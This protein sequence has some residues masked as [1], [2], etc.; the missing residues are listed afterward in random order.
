MKKIF[1][2]TCYFF[3]GIFVYSHDLAEAVFECDMPTVQKYVEKLNADLNKKTDYYI[4]NVKN[5]TYLFISVHNR[6]QGSEIEKRRMVKY[7]LEHGALID[8]DT[9]FYV[10]EFS[11]YEMLWVLY[12]YGN[13]DN[14][15]TISIGDIEAS[16]SP[17]NSVVNLLGSL[18][19]KESEYEELEKKKWTLLDY[20]LSSYFHRWHENYNYNVQRNLYDGVYDGGSIWDNK[21]TDN[22]YMIEALCRI[23]S[24]VNYEN[25]NHTVWLIAEDL[26]HTRKY[27]REG[28]AFRNIDFMAMNLLRNEELISFLKDLDF[29]KPANIESKK[30]GQT[31]FWI[32]QEY[33]KGKIDSNTIKFLKAVYSERVN[34]S[35]E[36]ITQ[37]ILDC[38]N[39]GINLHTQLDNFSK[40][41]PFIFAAMYCY[42]ETLEK[43]I[44]VDKN[45][46]L[47]MYDYVS[48]DVIK[49]RFNG[50]V[51]D[52]YSMPVDDIIFVKCPTEN[53]K[54]LREKF[55][56]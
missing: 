2:L 5:P 53:I 35:S 31:A 49:F 18:F 9:F 4:D 25:C 7:L 39:S 45:Y 23:S 47:K 27:L 33:F 12:N 54:F 17:I 24:T 13:F 48:D 3:I 55:G 32:L 38:I 26:D 41:N 40:Y 15:R 8:D 21:D 30:L 44:S 10:L 22:F 50:D 51:K 46:N 52:F 20:F 11:D 42:P 6:N 14:Y 43:I 19:G 29:Y 56:R 36:D 28:V 34:G 37:I 16:H 1:F